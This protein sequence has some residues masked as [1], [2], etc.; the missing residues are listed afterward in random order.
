[1]ADLV[2][3]TPLGIVDQ[4]VGLMRRWHRD[5]RAYMLQVEARVHADTH[6][7]R[8][9]IS[10]ATQLSRSVAGRVC[11]KPMDFATA[12]KWDLKRVQRKVRKPTP[13][14]IA[15]DHVSVSPEPESL[16][17]Y[18]GK[19][20]H[21]DIDLNDAAFIWDL[22]ELLMETRN[23]PSSGWPPDV[24]GCRAPT[25][26]ESEMLSILLLLGKEDVHRARAVWVDK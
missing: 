25:T 8:L 24:A 3:M 21:S 4:P 12:S 19:N 11:D 6:G 20:S 26:A 17:A 9:C 2:N 1:M 10:G 5:F 23:M 13:I 15:A 22:G 16:A 7:T 14:S 18:R